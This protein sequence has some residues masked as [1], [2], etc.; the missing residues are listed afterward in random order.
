MTDGIGITCS[1]VVGVVEDELLEVLEV[2]LAV[3]GVG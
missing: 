3:I 1:E 2:E